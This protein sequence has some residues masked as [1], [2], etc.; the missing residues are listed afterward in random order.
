MSM[1]VPAL[2]TD[3]AGA[4]ARRIFRWLDERARQVSSVNNF[5][6][7]IHWV[8]PTCYVGR[9]DV[10][11]VGADGE[12]YTWARVYVGEFSN[13]LMSSVHQF[14]SDE[15]AAFAYA[16]ERMRATASQLAVSNRASDAAQRVNAALSAGDV[17]ALLPATRITA[18][19][20]DGVSAATSSAAT[21]TVWHRTSPSAL[22]RVRDASASCAR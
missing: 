3:D 15:Q 9:G 8:S 12:E 1:A 20:D 17:A 4:F 13:G 16:E 14:E 18:I 5:F 21:R 11:A 6:S 2:D 19:D 22:Q 10:L 7:A